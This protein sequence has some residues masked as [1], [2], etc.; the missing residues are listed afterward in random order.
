MNYFNKRNQLGQPIK[1]GDGR[2]IG[3]IRG[4]CFFRYAWSSRHMLKVPRGWAQDESIIKILELAG[5]QIIEIVDSD[6][7]LVF[8]APLSEFREHGV[9]IDRGFGRQLALPLQYWQTRPGQSTNGKKE[10]K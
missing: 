9:I 1:S 10:G 2:V 7:G 5:V 3:Y 8:I 4:K 6:S